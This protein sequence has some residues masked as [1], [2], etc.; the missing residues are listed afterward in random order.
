MLNWIVKIELFIS[1]KRDLALNNLQR[2]ICHKTQTNKH[3]WAKL[4]CLKIFR[5]VGLDGNVWNYITVY[6]QTIIIIIMIMFD[7]NT[8]NHLTV[9]KLYILKCTTW[10]DFTCLW[11]KYCWSSW[12]NLPERQALQILKIMIL[13]SA[14]TW[15]QTL[16]THI[17]G[18]YTT[19]LTTKSTLG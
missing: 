7:R 9:W 11:W 3:L 14:S 19:A 4:I 12:I 13:N 6:K 17:D 15:F 1:I 5:I 18:N 2:L 10:S 8:W 16:A